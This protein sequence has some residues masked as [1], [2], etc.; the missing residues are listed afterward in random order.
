MAPL[1]IWSVGNDEIARALTIDDC[2]QGLYEAF[3]AL[4]T[5]KGANPQHITVPSEKGCVLFKPATVHGAGLGAKIMSVFPGN[6]SKTP[7]LPNLNGLIVMMDEDTGKLKAVLEADLITTM[8]TAGGSAVSVQVMAPEN[9]QVL[10]V[11]GAGPQAEWHIRM[12]V[13]VRPSIKQVY[14]VNRTFSTAELLAQRMSSVWDGVDIKA[15]ADSEFAV[16]QA[17][18]IATCTAAR[19]AL[20]EANWVK[21]TCHIAAVGSFTHDMREL[22]VEIFRD[23][24]V[25]VDC[26]LASEEAGELL[27]AFEMGTLDAAVL[28][29]I[30][31]W[32]R[33]GTQPTKGRRTIYKSVGFGLMDI[34]VSNKVLEALEA[35]F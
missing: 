3:D 13:H 5:D 27:D 14:V 21:P 2:L 16:R 24:D 22:P 30:G 11:F 28:P 4:G 26:G 1:S 18:I 31:N 25:V 34:A 23:A 6:S 10:T 9:C 17:D 20:F 33:H 19:A 15:T 12:M 7:P 32:I 8:R 29:T 35:E